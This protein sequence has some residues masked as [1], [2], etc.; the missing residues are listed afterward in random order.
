MHEPDG[1]PQFR[2]LTRP[3]CESLLTRNSVGR[4]AFVRAS[5]LDII[6]IHYVFAGNAL[7]G[8]TARGT[9]LEETSSNLTI[10]GR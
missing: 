5:L 1:K 8:R 4:V 3:E 7:C 6:P 10:H 2:A 9:R